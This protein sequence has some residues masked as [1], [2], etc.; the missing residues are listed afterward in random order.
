MPTTLTHAEVLRR[1]QAIVDASRATVLPP[2]GNE[3]GAAVHHLRS[4]LAL[5]DQLCRRILS[6][7][8]AYGRASTPEQRALAQRIAAEL[9]GLWPVALNR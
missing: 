5:A 8:T 4:Q 2:G 7:R 3:R 6:D 1:A 9:D